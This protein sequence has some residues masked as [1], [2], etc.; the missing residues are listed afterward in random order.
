M[1]CAF[2]APEAALAALCASTDSALRQLA[3]EQPP[4]PSTNSTLAQLGQSAA[5]ASAAQPHTNADPLSKLAQRTRLVQEALATTPYSVMVRLDA[6]NLLVE[7]GRFDDAVQVLDWSLAVQPGDCFT[8][9]KKA[10][11]LVLA[12]RPGDPPLVHARRLD[13]ALRAAAQADRHNG[14]PQDDVAGPCI[15]RAMLLSSNAE[16]ALARLNTEPHQGKYRLLR[17]MVHHTLGSQADCAKELAAFTRLRHQTPVGAMIAEFHAWQGNADLACDCLEQAI[18]QTP[19]DP[20]LAALAHSP[21]VRKISRHPRWLELL[22]GINRL[23][24]QLAS[25]P[26]EVRLPPLPTM[27]ADRLGLS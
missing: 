10:Q 11:I 12:M 23:P 22:G 5:V 3:C 19:K 20:F 16:G 25:I 8:L 15:A 14:E 17:A 2:G 21:F 7:L 9:L 24:E 26:F 6:V 18:T 4:A 27:H 13:A 1:S